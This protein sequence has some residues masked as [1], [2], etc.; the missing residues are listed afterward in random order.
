MAALEPGLV[1]VL[2]YGTLS[3]GGLRGW[4]TATEPRAA[5]ERPWAHLGGLDTL[6]QRL[7]ERLG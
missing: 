4:A 1:G 2:L 3:V 6:P 7:R 5:N